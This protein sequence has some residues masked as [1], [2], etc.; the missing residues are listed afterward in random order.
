MLYRAGWSNEELDDS[1]VDLRPSTRS[2]RQVGLKRQLSQ[3]VER[4]A[5]ILGHVSECIPLHE[6]ES[7]LLKSHGR[8]WL[9]NP[10]KN[11]GLGNL[12]KE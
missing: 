1:G 6:A 10:V 7:Q 3:I 4:C 12:S 9:A 8:S 5:G 11:G 2:E